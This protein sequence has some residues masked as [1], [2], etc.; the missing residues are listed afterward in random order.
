[1]RYPKLQLVELLIDAE[2]CEKQ[3]A[4]RVQNLEKQIADNMHRLLEL[5]ETE[6]RLNKLK[7]SNLELSTHNANIRASND[8]LSS[9]LRQVRDERD[10][11]WALLRK[12]VGRA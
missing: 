7:V 1:M 4:L 11:Y 12:L 5:E 9:E 10:T 8:R 2:S 3:D 6:R